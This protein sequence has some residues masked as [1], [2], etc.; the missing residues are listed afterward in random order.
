M[1]TKKDSWTD[2]CQCDADETEGREMFLKCSR[3]KGRDRYRK[4][5]QQEAQKI[6][7]TNQLQSMKQTKE[8]RMVL[9]Q[10]VNQRKK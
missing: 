2:F 7:K 10:L 6:V 8:G 1:K 9:N 3:C 5:T 4:L